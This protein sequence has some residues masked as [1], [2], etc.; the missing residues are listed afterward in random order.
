MTSGGRV[1]AISIHMPGPATQNTKSL[2]R[3]SEKRGRV[4]VTKDDDF[5]KDA[6]EHKGRTGYIAIYEVAD[7]Q[8]DED[9]LRFRF[10]RRV[11]D[12]I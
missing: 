6:R 5:A 9:G 2:F 4:I 12:L 8:F 10:T 7:V 11:A 1:P 3:G